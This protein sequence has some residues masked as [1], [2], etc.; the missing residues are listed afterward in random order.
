MG[1]RLEIR[2]RT[3]ILQKIPR[4]SDKYF[5]SR[6]T[7]D[8]TQR[9]HELRTLRMLPGLGMNILWLSFQIILTMIAVIILVPESAGIA[10]LATCFAVSISFISQPILIEQ[11][12]RLRTHLAGM[13]RFYLDALLGLIPIRTHHA[14]RAVR[15]EHEN[16]LLEWVRTS[17]D[18]LKAVTLIGAVESLVQIGFVIW[19][20]SDYIGKG[21]DPSGILLLFYW[22][23]NLP[24]LG[25]TLAGFTQQYPMYRNRILRLLEPLTA[26]EEG[27]ET[28]MKESGESSQERSEG[29]KSRQPT[30]T[31]VSIQLENVMVHAGGQ[32]IL[33][34]MNLSVKAGEHIAVVGSSGAGKSSLVGIFLGWHR[35][36]KGNVWVD[37]KELRGD[38]LRTLRKETVWVDPEVQLWNRSLFENLCYGTYSETPLLSTVIEQADLFSVM[39]TLPNG[40][41]TRLGEGGGL[42]S[43]G[44]GQRVRLG[45]GMLREQIRLVI[46][47]EPFRGL[48][49]EKR[50]QLLRKARKHWKDAT[51]IFIS[52]DVSGALTFDRVLVI[53]NGE[54]AEDDAPSRLAEDADSRYYHLIKSEEAI[55]RGLWE[56]AEWRHLWLE[57]GRISEKG[58]KIR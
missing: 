35:P 2:F 44:E 39:E 45:R 58:C 9:V 29:K 55:R 6:L 54:I 43:G 53:E 30:A 1:R 23:L 50:R 48:D 57:N 20:L 24:V 4:L 26:S 47:D 14:E 10:L 51:L 28:R 12:M 21:P 11:D 31:G 37:G 42:I 22:T 17:M 41:K 52:H 32:T 25:K 3:A 5:H 8:M 13:S 56:S 36:A 27:E 34:D 15:R 16:L 38:L 18:F 49:R 7:S 33:K 19:L 46:L 40:M